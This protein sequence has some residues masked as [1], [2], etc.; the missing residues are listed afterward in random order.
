LIRGSRQKVIL[1]ELMRGKLPP[2][3][4]QGPKVGFDIPAHEWMRGPLRPMLLEV[5]AG[6]SADHADLFNFPAIHGFV[7]SHLNRRV[8]LGYHLWGLMTLFLWM[9]KWKVQSV[10]VPSRARRAAETFCASA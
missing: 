2:A 8:N 4:I 10:P 3:A 5:L 1:R 6:A 7:Q 9:K